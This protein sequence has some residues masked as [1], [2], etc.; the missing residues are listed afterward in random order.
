MLA[1]RPLIALGLVAL[2][3]G[4]GAF[5]DWD[6]A[7]LLGGDPIL[8]VVLAAAIVLTV[9]TFLKPARGLLLAAGIAVSFIPA[10]VLFVFGAIGAL[11]DPGDMQEF[12]GAFLFLVAI[13]LALPAAIIGFRQAKP[14]ATGA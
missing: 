8:V 13:G 11:A 9:L 5:F 10:L 6:Y 7:S 4:E 3:I 14:A 2:V 1:P 12:L